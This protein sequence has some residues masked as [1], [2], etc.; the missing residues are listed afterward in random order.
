PTW[1][2][3]DVPTPPVL[4]CRSPQGITG[5]G[6]ALLPLAGA[7]E[8]RLPSPENLFRRPPSKGGTPPFARGG[9]AMTRT[10][11]PLSRRH[12]DGGFVLAAGRPKEVRH[13]R[14]PRVPRPPQ[15][16]REGR[17]LLPHPRPGLGRRLRRRHLLGRQ[18]RAAAPAPRLAAGRPPRPGRLGGPVP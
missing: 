18:P 11:P 17:H 9:V 7:T 8:R 5:A 4:G 10:P 13:V 3:S 6:D 2:A 14:V 1:G 16:A 15:P 12:R